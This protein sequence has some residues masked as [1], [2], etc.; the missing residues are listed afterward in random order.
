MYRVLK[1]LH[2]LGLTL[3]LGS[4]FGHIVVS[5]LGGGPHSPLFLF[6]RQN[7]TTATNV[8]TIPGL[9]L[10]I[11]SGI[12]MAVISRLSPLRARWLALH[13]SLAL[14]VAAIAA[15][16]IIPAGRD[17]LQGAIALRDGSPDVAAAQI[18]TAKRIEDIAGAINILLALTIAAIGVWKP[19]L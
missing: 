7:V 13:G 5:V 6:A 19:K 17:M 3:F 4:I 12:G 16:A 15:V 11:V 8:L 1:F 9:G 14:V 2:L 10:A 18:L